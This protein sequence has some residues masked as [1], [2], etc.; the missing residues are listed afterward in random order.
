[1]NIQ[2]LKYFIAVYEEKNITAAARKCNISQP[3][4]SNA[5]KD[6]EE[7]LE[8]TLF[9]RNKK[10]VDITEEAHYLY[11]L[12]VRIT[13]NLA[14][15]PEIFHKSKETLHLKLSIFQNLS[16]SRISLLLKLIGSS[17]TPLKISLFSNDQKADIRLTLDVLKREDEIFLPLWEEDYKL[18][19]PKDHP[20]TK[21]NSVKP[22]DLHKFDF[23]ECPS[24]E[25]HQQT[26]GLVAC[27]GLHLNI[28]ASGENKC[29]VMYLVEAGIGVSFLP[30]GVLEM[31]SNLTTVNFEGPRMFR[32]IG[33]CY[34]ANKTLQPVVSKVIKVLTEKTIT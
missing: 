17:I 25:A 14:K 29:Q 21:F 12:A 30:T 6:L 18:C 24:C 34:P 26:I 5:I 32:R 20:L 31:S 19:C 15:L 27:E 33:I 1:M 22:A 16:P 28:I 8:T 7:E 3:S 4:I 2:H 13:N 23:L 11:P 9:I 10:G